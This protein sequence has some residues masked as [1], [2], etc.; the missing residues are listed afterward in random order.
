VNLK[1]TVSPHANY[2]SH[3]V[4]VDGVGV[5]SRQQMAG[6]IDWLTANVS[7]EFGASTQGVWYLAGWGSCF[8]FDY[9]G[10]AL[11]FYMNFSGQT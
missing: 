1:Y 4:E 10:D 3:C 9:E 11:M 7:E 8:F 5:A 6:M 2:F